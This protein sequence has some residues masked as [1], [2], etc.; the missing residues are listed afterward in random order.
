MAINPSGLNQSQLKELRKKLEDKR[1]SLD[2]EIK[3]IEIELT[4]DDSEQSAP[5]EVDRSSFEEQV[6]RSQ[7]VLDQKK[8]LRFEVNEAIKRLD[9]GT[10]G[11]CEET[12]EPIGF[13][14]LAAQPWT[15]LSLDAQQEFEQKNRNRAYGAGGGSGFPSAYEDE[16]G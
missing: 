8:T 4:D 16:E 9:D 12:E 7:I 2:S 13:K 14:R 3:E 5:D 10:Y 1:A 15:R 11:V 6:Q